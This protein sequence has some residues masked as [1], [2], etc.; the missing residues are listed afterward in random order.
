MDAKSVYEAHKAKSLLVNLRSTEQLTELEAISSESSAL[1][2]VVRSYITKYQNENVVRDD[3]FPLVDALMENGTRRIKTELDKRRKQLQTSPPRT[4]LTLT[5]PSCGCLFENPVTLACG[6]TVCL[7]C[8]RRESNRIINGNSAGRKVISCCLCDGHHDSDERFSVNLVLSNII[9][10]LFPKKG[11]QLE[12]KNLGKKHLLYHSSKEAVDYF[13]FV[14]NISPNDYDCHCLRSDAYSQLNLHYLALRDASNACKLRPDLP[15]AFHKKAKIFSHIKRYD[16][17]ITEYLR[18]AVLDPTDCRRDEFIDS[19]FQ[20]ITTPEVTKLEKQIVARKLANICVGEERFNDEEISTGIEVTV[21][22]LDDKYDRDEKN[23]EH[24]G[25]TGK[26][27]IDELKCDA[28]SCLLFRPVTTK[29]G[30]TFCQECLKESLEYGSKC[31][32]C[33]KTLN[34]SDERKRNFTVMLD[35]LIKVEFKRQYLERE[36]QIQEKMET[37]K[38]MG[39]DQRVEIPILVAS[40][41]ISCQRVQLTIQDPSTR[42]V[43]RRCVEWGSRMFGICAPNEDTE[44]GFADFGTLVEIQA[45]EKFSNGN[46]AVRA[47]PRRKFI[48]LSCGSIDGFV[49]AKVEWREDAK[50]D[51]GNTIVQL[52]WCNAASHVMLK[53]WVSTLPLEERRCVENTLGPLPP[54]ESYMLLA[55]N[56]PSWLWWAMAALPLEPQEKLRIMI[57]PSVIE[58]LQ[59]IQKFLRLLLKLSK[60]TKKRS[61]LI[62]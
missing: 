26:I 38:R 33:D 2:A 19:L 35:Q 29:C 44:K 52:K 31:P 16:D 41:P 56:G 57:T 21:C 59:S 55:P 28:C 40:I 37:W 7:D 23:F 11:K 46:L 24:S 42:V 14:L 3:L 54:C 15:D 1:E 12:L 6:H 8:L 32:S 45:T 13:S 51:D 20:L 5:C 61:N 43:I 9:T 62:E 58:R 34:D 49:V 60:H 36:K 10:K 47:I 18:C 17:A 27:D 48:V 39:V 22:L 4:L 50:I 30:H 53:K 25:E